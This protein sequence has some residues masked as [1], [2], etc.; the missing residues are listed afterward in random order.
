[1]TGDAV[2]RF[3][4]LPGRLLLDTCVLNLLQDEG[5]YIFE[6]EL[7]DDANEDQLSR[8]VR[9][10]RLIFQVNQR[11]A[12]QF[13]VS[14]L[15]VGELAAVPRFAER[16]AR[17]RWAL[18]ILDTWQIAVWEAEDNSV[19]QRRS[20]PPELLQVEQHLMEIPDLR[21]NPY[22][23]LLLLET[24]LANC[25]AFL[26][27]DERTILRHQSKLLDLGIRVMRPSE[28]WRLLEPWAP[29]WL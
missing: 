14:P 7:P 8:E 4:S 13:V 12:F 2:R 17:V 19:R 18:D 5:G 16:E 9:A 10:L 24:L 15:T 1:M 21:R 11:A 23:R 28:F 29:L 20:L 3:E 26:T 27:T 25:D 6:G 22:D